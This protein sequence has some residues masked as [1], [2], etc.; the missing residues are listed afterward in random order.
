MSPDPVDSAN[1]FGPLGPIGTMGAG[2][3]PSLLLFDLVVALKQLIRML[4][5]GSPIGAFGLVV[6]QHP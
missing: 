3:T 5:R 1:H 4:D 6:W 2:S